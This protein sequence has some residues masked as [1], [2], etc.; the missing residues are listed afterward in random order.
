M[1]APER[2]TLSDMLKTAINNLADHSEHVLGLHGSPTERTS[3]LWLNRHTPPIP[4]SHVITLDPEA[5][6]AETQ[7]QVEAFIESRPEGAPIGVND[8]FSNLDLATVGR[9]VL[10][11]DLWF[12]REPGP[13]ELRTPDELEIVTVKRA[14]QVAE[15]NR[16]EALGFG[17]EREADLYLAPIVEDRRHRLLIGR[18]DGEL[19]CSVLT[20][21]NGDSVGVYALSTVPYA[22][23]KGY[24]EA[25]V[26]AAL[27]NN[28][29]LPAFTNP[30]SMSNGLF[31]RIG[32]REIG[33][34]TIWV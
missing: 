3:T 27:L 32:F 34:R 16:A 33:K 5:D 20:F 19:V 1:I 4:Y 8:S 17:G 11:S 31:G 21:N 25:I 22:R 23:N 15:F 30:S 12:F 29:E 2:I 10:F 7:S 9:K 13:C 24:G 14:A 26:R 6:A 28:D 18:V